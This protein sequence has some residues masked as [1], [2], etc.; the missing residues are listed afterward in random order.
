MLVLF[1]GVDSVLFAYLGLLLVNVCCL[2]CLFSVLY[3][4]G[5]CLI[6]LFV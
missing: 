3:V 2:L 1:I 5:F 4:V 6:Y